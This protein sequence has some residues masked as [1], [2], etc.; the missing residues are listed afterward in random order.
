[1]GFFEIILQNRTKGGMREPFKK[2]VH[3]R[4]SIGD[5]TKQLLGKKKK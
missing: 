3:T 1:M 5:L 2:S 4:K